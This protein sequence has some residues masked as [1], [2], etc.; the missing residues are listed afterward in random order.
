MSLEL[1]RERAVQAL[2]SHFAQDHLT[3]QELELRFE[4]VYRAASTAELQ[5]LLGGLPVLVPSPVALETL[6]Q[7]SVAPAA[8]VPREKRYLA[9]MGE[10][11]RKGNWTV[12]SR[13]RL[14][15]AMG[16]IRLDL[17]E[18]LIPAE[19]VE[20]DATAM[21]GEVRIVLPP[22]LHAEV[23]GLAVMGEFSDRTAGAASTIDAPVIRVKGVAFMGAVRVETRLPTEGMMEAWKRRLRG[24]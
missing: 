19:G 22:G 2:A 4:K 9:F 6:P 12:P 17:R 13:L 11:R 18:A 10:V 3:T 14:L 20:I 23:D 7:Y 21:M 8:T 16:A 15:S 24:A 1:E 5:A